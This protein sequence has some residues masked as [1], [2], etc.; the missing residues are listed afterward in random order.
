MVAKA[1]IL[2][3]NFKKDGLAKYKLDYAS[4][5]KIN[6]RLIYCSITGFGRQGRTRTAPVTISWFRV[7]AASCRSP[8]PR[9]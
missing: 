8:A 3:E 1:D 6:P 7:T 5:A 2:I 9:G 4:L